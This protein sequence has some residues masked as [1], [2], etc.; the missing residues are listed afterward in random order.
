M[1]LQKSTYSLNKK[2]DYV[3]II[4]FLNCF[5]PSNRQN[6]PKTVL[7]EHEKL[8]KCLDVSTVF[9]SN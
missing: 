8:D 9:V 1:F 5:E 3:D 7:E 4:F 6:F 2:E